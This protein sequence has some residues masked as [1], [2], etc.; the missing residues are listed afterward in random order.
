MQKENYDCFY[1][2]SRC[3]VTFYK[4]W[5]YQG[6]IKYFSDVSLP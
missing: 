1:E 4:Q 3:V 6:D 2:K 5:Q